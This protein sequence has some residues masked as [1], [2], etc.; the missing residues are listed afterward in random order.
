LALAAGEGHAVLFD[1]AAGDGERG[2]FA[3]LCLDPWRVIVA[4][5][6]GT[7]VDGVRAHV[8]PFTALR[9][10]LQAMAE[11]VPADCPLPFPSGAAGY[12]GYESGRHIERLP[13]TKPNA[14][15]LPEVVMGLYDTVVGWDLIARKAWILAGRRVRPDARDRA[16][17]L[18]ARI[19]KAAPP[20]PTDWTLRG[21][22]TPERPRDHVEAAIARTVAY[23]HAGDIFQANI[24]QRFLGRVP[25]GLDDATLYARLRALSPA[26]FAAF[27]RVG[28][29]H[30]I[31]SAS[32][33]RFLRLQ[34]D[35]RV[36]T[37]PI[38]G[39]RP[40]GATPEEDARLAEELRTS[41]KDRAENLM[42]VDLMRNDL[43]RVCALGSVAVPQSRGLETF[44]RVHHL[45][46]AVEGRLR[47]GLDAIDLL[48]A[49]FPGGS[50]TGAPKIRAMEIID[51]LEPARRDAYCGTIAW[52]GVDGSMDSNI[53]IRTLTR[54]RDTLVA[55]AGGGIVAD[56]DPAA[57]YE[58]SLV[59]M[60]ALL[61]A[62]T[63]DRP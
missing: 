7:R 5:D 48:R 25:R 3:Y 37:R 34:S 20:P 18:A 62:L 52:I 40:R 14:L 46:S 19:A 61:A 23:I 8:D 21:S 1:S 26:P 63:G 11:A 9:S 10:G 38:K 39:T 41:E 47:P 24:T 2:R 45:V 36:E 4:D 16:D 57:E 44:S 49:T 27:L 32:P 50:I 51:E 42:I 54:A 58:E 35:G 43:G 33:E 13:P 56:S 55:Q 17:A 12:I 59:K 60:A 30:A 15:A 31:L 28:P 22:W 53:V 29:D 6:D